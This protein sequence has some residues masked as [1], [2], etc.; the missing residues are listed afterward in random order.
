MSATPTKGRPLGANRVEAARAEPRL[1]VVPVAIGVVVLLAIA[2]VVALRLAGGDDA[3][4]SN[5]TV[6]ERVA[7]AAAGDT[8]FSDVTVDGDALPELDDGDDPAVGQVAP[9]LS[10]MSTAGGALTVDPTEGPMVIAFL[11]NW[12]PHCQ[13]EVPRL[14]E[15]ADGREEVDG[16]RLVGVA[17]RSDERVDDTF[18]PGDWLADKGW[19][20]P[21]LA[22]SETS[23]D[24][25]PTAAGAY[26]LSG[27]PFLVAVDADGEVVARA[28]G[29]QG[30]E[31]L[32]D[33]FDAARRG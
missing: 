32:S 15:L 22:D 13:A 2:A 25:L 19:T 11:A 12:C 16:V 27:L 8:A 14:V 24:E 6:T 20:G 33:L 9:I 10:G 23:G 31:G 29:E 28:S 4:A 21:V 3:D 5:A 7:S 18:P 30:E 1:P 26:G 17:T